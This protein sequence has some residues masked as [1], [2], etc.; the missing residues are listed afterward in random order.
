MNSLVDGFFENSK[1]KKAVNPNPAV[2]Q[3][4]AKFEKELFVNKIVDE[5]AQELFDPSYQL[6]YRK[7]GKEI[8]T[9]YPV[10]STCSL[11]LV[12]GNWDISIFSAMP[13]HLEYLKEEMCWKIDSVTKIKIS[14]LIEAI[15][16]AQKYKHDLHLS[17]IHTYT[18]IKAFV[19]K[20]S[21]LFHDKDKLSE[22]A[23]N[24]FWNGEIEEISKL[25]KRLTS[26]KYDF[27][28]TFLL[29]WDKELK[30]EKQ[31]SASLFASSMESDLHELKALF[32]KLTASL[33]SQSEDYLAS[34]KMIWFNEQLMN[35]FQK[36]H[37]TVEIMRRNTNKTRQFT[38]DLNAVIE[39][40]N[41]E[42][43]EETFLG[44]DTAETFIEE[45]IDETTEQ[46]LE[47]TGENFF[48]EESVLNFSPSSIG[49]LLSSYD[50]KSEHIPFIVREE[51]LPYMYAELHLNEEA[52]M[53]LAAHLT[54]E[55]KYH[56][57]LVTL[58]TVLVKTCNTAGY[59]VKE[60]LKKS[61]MVNYDDTKAILDYCERYHVKHLAVQASLAN[62]FEKVINDFYK[63][64]MI[65][66]ELERVQEKEEQRIYWNYNVCVYE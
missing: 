48:I 63:F 64:N 53:T 30:Y 14:G 9:L 31:I 60:E 2:S 21:L 55:E 49:S 59:A 24:S 32:S 33:D 62:F 56:L 57:E 54:N 8:V 35:D 3:F 46:F 19:L 27:L 6:I 13:V 11:K 40:L 58:I 16:K 45:L 20:N 29:N 52:V 17:L 18:V 7:N 41:E 26:K 37:Q 23:V 44:M 4:I 42:E 22:L 28:K 61:F 36:F 66:I 34:V 39:Q 47:K 10:K 12:S 25:Y 51:T 50:L 65:K 1:I 38:K 43:A 5:A 15:K